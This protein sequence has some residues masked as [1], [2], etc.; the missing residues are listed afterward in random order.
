MIHKD[1]KKGNFDRNNK[2]EY[3]NPNLIR[4]NG[5]IKKDQPLHCD[6][7]K[8]SIISFPNNSKNNN[9]INVE[10]VVNTGTRKRKKNFQNNVETAVILPKINAGVQKNKSKY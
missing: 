9:Q 10:T 1:L 2:H 5:Q 7:P 4:N 8:S 6:F 3:Q